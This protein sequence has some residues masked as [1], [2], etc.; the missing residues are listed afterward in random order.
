VGIDTEGAVVRS[1][2]EEWLGVLPAERGADL[3]RSKGVL[4]LA[5]TDRRYVFQG[6]HMLHHGE[7]GAPWRP[8]ESRRNRM[9]FIGRD[10]DRAELEAGFRACL[11]AVP[12]GASR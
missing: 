7:L 11:R 4:N 12:A 3:F 5:D 2:L 9:V 1:R 6:V 8:E 10:L